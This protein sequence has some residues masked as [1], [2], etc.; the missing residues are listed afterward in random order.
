MTGSST[1]SVK[2]F[3]AT[4]KPWPIPNNT[5]YAPIW[6]N[7]DSPPSI[8]IPLRDNTGQNISSRNAHYSE[9]TAWYWIWKNRPDIDI[10]GLCHYRRYF[11]LLKDHPYF[12]KDKIYM[13][14]SAENIRHFSEIQP[15]EAISRLCADGVVITPR[16]VRL[17]SSLSQHYRDCHRASDWD[18]FLQAISE[19]SP[20]HARHL[21][22]LE[23]SNQ[24]FAYNMMICNRRF[25]EEYF[26]TLM[27]V[28]EKVETM[29][30][31]P[32]DPYQ[33]RIPAFLSERFFS[34]HLNLTKPRLI[35]API[36]LT[37]RNAF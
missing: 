12:S 21:D 28:L 22:F 34:L 16:P 19:A 20:E 35:T 4:H 11:F 7:P 13:D 9:L 3:V 36:L 30:T 37:D 26:T 6:V 31:Y 1:R 18:A 27:A 8:D 29:I 17:R 23:T 32:E 15:L 24:L 5:L 33:K 2:I 14:P 10:V 25:L